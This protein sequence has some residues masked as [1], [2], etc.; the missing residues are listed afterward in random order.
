MIS[1][2]GKYRISD[3]E[4]TEYKKTKLSVAD[5]TYSLSTFIYEHFR[6]AIDL[7]TNGLPFGSVNVSPDG[8][9]YFIRLLLAEVYGKYKLRSTIHCSQSYVEV[10]IFHSESSI[11]LEYMI[12]VARMS[13][14][15]VVENTDGYTLLIT[16]VIPEKRPVFYAISRFIFKKCLYNMFFDA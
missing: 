16:D 3:K 5:F 14:F 1:N 6:G 10:K 8:L 2:I 12:K 7:S 13:G 15:H 4:P 9:A 11:D